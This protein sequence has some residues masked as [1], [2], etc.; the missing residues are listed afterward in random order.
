MLFMGQNIR[1]I[2]KTW[3]KAMIEENKAMI[4]IA[5]NQV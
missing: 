5:Y 1:I 2:T 4:G 3:L